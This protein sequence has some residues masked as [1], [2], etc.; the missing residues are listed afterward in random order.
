M[1]AILAIDACHGV[2]QQLADRAIGRSDEHFRLV[3]EGAQ[4]CPQSSPFLNNFA[5]LLATTPDDDLRDG[6]RALAMIERSIALQGGEP[7][8]E[9]LDTLAAAQ[10]ETGDFAA[11]AR[12]QRAALRALG[13]RGTPPEAMAPYRAHLEAYEAGRPVREP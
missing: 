3:A 6:R 13:A 2:R 7:G 8:P 11:A 10:A 5:W 1:R 9:L 12:H 4:R